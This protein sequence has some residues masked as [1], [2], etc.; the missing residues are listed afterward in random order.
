MQLITP[1]DLIFVNRSFDI[2][3]LLESVGDECQE[4]H[5]IAIEPDKQRK[6]N[7]L[8]EIINRE[9]T[10]RTDITDTVPRVA[11]VMY[12]DVHIPSPMDA[13]SKIIIFASFV[14]TIHKIEKHLLQH[15]ISFVSLHG[16]A[17]ILNQCVNEF[18]DNKQ[19]LL[20]NASFRCA[21]LNLEF[22]TDVV[23][24]HR[25]INPAIESQVIGRAQ[26]IGRKSCL[27]IHYLLYTNE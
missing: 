15:N 19:V 2:D 8:L 24:F 4:F 11:G 10:P 17:N 26:R 5:D 16:T 21:G 14:E 1:A 23:F 20:V 7:A 6:L 9:D 25:I 22:A 27:R 12:G 13:G 18:R 3:T